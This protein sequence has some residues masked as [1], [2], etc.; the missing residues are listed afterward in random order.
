MKLTVLGYYGGYPDHGIGTSSYLLQS[1]GFNLLIDCGSGALLSL[2]EVLDPLKLDAVI[3]SHYHYDHTADVGVLQYYW[4]LHPEG[5]KQAILPIYGHA[6]D[7]PQ[8]DALNWA[9]ATE[10]HAYSVNEVL[11]LGPF[12]I[13]LMRTQHPVPAF[14]M[15]IEEIQTGKVLAFTADT[16]YFDNLVEFSKN[17]E[18]L[19]TD[20]N[21]FNDKTGQ[22]WHLTAGES[23]YLAHQANVKQL[24]LTHLPQVGD[25]DTLVAQAKET[26][27]SE[28]N[29]AHVKL[30]QE[31][32][33]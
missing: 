27:G 29:V 8:L 7:Q 28:I 20:T 15:R 24:L 32:V 11:N 30:R 9:G 6:E 2:E 10:A 4:Q 33:I 14:A 16:N 22:R 13:K 5:H 18:L 3:L 12:K 19:L 23:G 1:E 26:A 17:A 21:F 25:L 31:I